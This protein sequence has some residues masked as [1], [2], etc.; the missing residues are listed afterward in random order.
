MARITQAELARRLGLSQQAVSFALAESDQVSPD[1]RERVLA[2]AERLGYRRNVSAL[3]MLSGRMGNAALLSVEEFKAF[4]P[5]DIISGAHTELEKMGYHLVVY[6]LLKENLDDKDYVPGIMRELAVD[7]FLIM[8]DGEGENRLRKW[9]SRYK[10]PA[11]WLN[12]K[13]KQNCAYP[14]DFKLAYEA[15]RKLIDLGHER[16]WMLGRRPEEDSHYSLFDRRAGYSSAMEEAMLRP[17]F[18]SARALA[19]NSQWLKQEGAPTACFCYGVEDGEDAYISA[20]RAGLEV[21]RDLSIIVL[22]SALA[23]IG[24]RHF[25]N[26]RQPFYQV[27]QEAVRLLEKRVRLNGASV[28]SHVE[29]HIQFDEGETVGPPPG[30]NC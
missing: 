19:E 27:A 29:N 21:P 3:S 1:T 14:N 7:G 17:R 18:E 20:C 11:I 5:H 28:P 9:L 22:G 13:E 23:H 8:Y 10:I 24:S 4:M 12:R 15:T 2:E 16:I 6:S 25:C 30:E 26:L